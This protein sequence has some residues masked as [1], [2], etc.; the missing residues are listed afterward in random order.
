MRQ[1]LAALARVDL[2]AR[3]R[4]RAART[5]VLPASRLTP[6]LVGR[7]GL[8]RW[9]RDRWQRGRRPAER[10]ADGVSRA[11]P[12]DDRPAGRRARV[13]VPLVTAAALAA[14]ATLAGW[15]LLGGV[16]VAS[17]AWAPAPQTTDAL[18]D[19]AR[20]DWIATGTGEH[21][22]GD[23][24]WWVLAVLGAP[25]GSPSTAVT[26]LLVA[27]PLLAGASAWW[28]AGALTRTPWWRAV[29]ALTW[30]ATPA[31]L[32]GVGDARVGAV[33][34]HVALPL[35]ARAV[36]QSATSPFRRSVWS[37]AGTAAL[38]LMVVTAGAPVWSSRPP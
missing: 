7:R 5:R 3:A 8:V 29:A 10:G 17:A 27:A 18:W 15:R 20:S 1:T 4:R 2:V 6:L 37:W 23:A 9:H 32:V 35:V 21:G 14:A 33:L 13:A 36:A 38:A 12:V 25:L 11:L 31:L 26:A 22:P 34:A 28:A 19:A 30:A 16:P 24:L